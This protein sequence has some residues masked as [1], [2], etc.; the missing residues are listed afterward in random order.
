[1]GCYSR[2]PFKG[3]RGIPF[4]GLRGF[5]NRVPFKSILGFE[6]GVNVKGFFF[7]CSSMSSSMGLGFA[8]RVQS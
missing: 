2:V 7:C 1:M 8:L 4:K 3:L 6:V 5:H